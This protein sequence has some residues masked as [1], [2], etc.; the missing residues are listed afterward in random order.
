MIDAHLHINHCD[1]SIEQ[2][3]EH[4]LATGCDAAVVMGCEPESIHGVSRAETYLEMLRM[5]PDRVIAGISVDPRED[6]ALE[7]V[8]RYHALGFRHL[9]E[10]KSPVPVD[11]PRQLDLFRLAGELGLPVTV[12]FEEANYNTGFANFEAVLQSYP[13]T[14]F[15]GHAQTWWAN[16]SADNQADPGYPEGPVAPGGLTD[17]WLGDYENLYADLSAGSGDNALSRDPDFSRGFFERHWR[18][19][20][21][22]TDCP[23][24]DGHGAGW[25]PGYCFSTGKLQAIHALSPSPEAEHAILHGTAARL[26]GWS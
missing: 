14:I 15:I 20:I 25:E 10:L 8:V 7:V 24:H 26:W 21:Y 9:G 22:A 2:T 12:H 1:R 6:D 18:K 3:L 5:Y 17:R 16:V 11:H 4:I 13:S 19:L 23:C